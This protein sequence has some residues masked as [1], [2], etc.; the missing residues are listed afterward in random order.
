MK[1]KSPK[2]RLKMAENEKKA[3][4]GPRK[5]NERPIRLVKCR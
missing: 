2:K 5:M 1:G 4:Y 3:K